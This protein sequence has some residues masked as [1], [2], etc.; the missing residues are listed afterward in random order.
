MKLWTA[1]AFAVALLPGLGCQAHHQ[2]VV[3]QIATV[4]VT[5]S[6]LAE[7]A[8]PPADTKTS[9]RETTV[10]PNRPAGEDRVTLPPA[11]RYWGST[12]T[13]RV[14]RGSVSSVSEKD[15]VAP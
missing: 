10:A 7:P 12:P 1:S 13:A 14:F 2:D 8:V 9:P 6:I 5:D 11:S 4:P 3:R 15:E